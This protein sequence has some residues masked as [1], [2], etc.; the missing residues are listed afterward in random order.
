MTK[1][2]RGTSQVA[3]A[4]PDGYT[5]GLT[6]T[7]AVVNN[8]FLMTRLPYDPRRDLAYINE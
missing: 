1:A 3:K 6:L 4:A 8:L 5:I 7:Q 2:V